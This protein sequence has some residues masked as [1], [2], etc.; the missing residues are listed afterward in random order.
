MVRDSGES[1][2]VTTMLTLD[3]FLDRL[4]P[5]L[6][7]HPQPVYLV[8]GAVRDALLGRASHD[9]DLIVAT[10]AITL[11]FDLA[12]RLGLPA[13]RLDDERD[14]GRILVPGSATT[15]DIARFRGDSLAN[16]LRGRDFTINALA[17]PVAA[18]TAGAVIDHH[19]GLADL[20]AGRIRAVH[21]HAISDDPVRALRAARFVVQLGYAPT[22]E[23]VAAIRAAGPLLSGRTSPE[24]TR[25][26]ISRLL[27]TDAPERA[28]A[29]LQTWGLLAHALPVVAALDGV[30]Q[31]APHHEDVLRHTLSV[32]RYLVLVERIADGAPVAAAWAAAVDELLNPFRPALRAYLDTTLDGGFVGRL[33]LRWSALLHDV[34]KPQTQTIDE[35]GR[36]R[37]LGHDDAGA[38]LTTT[39]L[40]RLKFSGAAVRRVRDTVAGH[41]RPLYLAKEGRSPSRRTVYR[42]YRALHTA[43]IDVALLSLADHL[44]T[45]DGPGP[46]ESWTA[47]LAIVGMLLD[48]YFTAYTETVAPPRLLNGL[49]V[50]ELLGIEPGRE[51][52][53]LL[54]ELEEAQ[55]A[56]EVTTREAAVTFLRRLAEESSAD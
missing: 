4:R 40:N 10:G 43:G 22:A 55:A 7:D 17:L 2:Y 20:A 18:R 6:A 24:R 35:A 42:Y 38:A 34:G 9:I 50:M 13:Y 21:D 56:G 44:A 8:G 5:L 33:L 23:T 14:V 52:G 12:R 32:L 28:V 19:D 30:A 25:D 51:L 16:D 29:L 54:A 31:S 41:M 36:I 26:E 47:L 15:L 45:Y 39:L 37:F 53:R 27:G 1:R 11:T 49:E 46:G 48:T 3:P